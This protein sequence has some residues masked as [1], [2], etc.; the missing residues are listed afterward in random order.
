MQK[1][2]RFINGLRKFSKKRL[3]PEEAATLARK[4]IKKRVAA[5][6]D[7]FLNLVER[8]IFQNAK[9]PYLKLLRPKRIA[10]R[11]VKSWVS[12]QG[13]EASLR[14]LENEGIYFTVDEF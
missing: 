6:E 4:F 7:N 3:A 10:F 1:Y 8:G 11:D 5:R 9:S 2:F 13:L 12:K 14:T